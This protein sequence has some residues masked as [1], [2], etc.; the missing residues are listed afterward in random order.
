MQANTRIGKVKLKRDFLKRQVT[1]V[2]YAYLDEL[3]LVRCFVNVGAKEYPG[4]YRG[5]KDSAYESAIDTLQLVTQAMLEG[6][7]EAA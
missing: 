5:N 3:S 7:R 2:R 4:E 6:A 1:G